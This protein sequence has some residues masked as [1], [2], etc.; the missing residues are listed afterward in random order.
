MR[1][2]HEIRGWLMRSASARSLTLSSPIS[3]SRC[4]IRRRVGLAR[5]RKWS[6]SSRRAPGINI[7]L[8]LCIASITH[9]GLFMGLRPR[10]HRGSHRDVYF[11]IPTMARHKYSEPS[12]DLAADI[13]ESAQQLVRLEIA[14]AKQ[15]VKE[16]AMRNGIA[17]G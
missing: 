12:A 17:I 14:L 16:L 15:E 3:P 7:S 13:V 11:L 6:E 5:A 2:C 1:R 4:R 8:P 9:K 10:I